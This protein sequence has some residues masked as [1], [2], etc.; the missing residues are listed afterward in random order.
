MDS[1]LHVMDARLLN[2]PV[3]KTLISVLSRFLKLGG[4]KIIRPIAVDRL[5]ACYMVYEL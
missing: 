4:Q 5:S 3:F 2:E 1:A